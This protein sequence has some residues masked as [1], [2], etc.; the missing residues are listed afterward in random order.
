MFNPKSF[1]FEVDTA[2]LSI[3]EVTNL[4]NIFFVSKDYDW[5]Y[6]V[7]PDDVVVDIGAS[8]GMFSAKALDA[9]AKK[10]YMIEPSKKLLKTAVKNVSDYIIGNN[11]LPRVVPINAAVGR[12]DIDLSNVYGNNEVKLMSLLEFCVDF[13]VEQID[14][15]K[16]NAAGAEY[17]ILHRDMFDFLVTKVRHI[18][19]RC[20]LDAQYGSIDKFREWRDTVLNPMIALGRV[21]VQND[22]YIEKIQSDQFAELMPKSFMLYI[23]NW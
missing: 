17:N 5:W 20:H 15:L 8:V 4:H 3:N 19:V 14:F 23:R 7:L 21:Y 1:N 11:E 9:G 18:A 16:I 2:D 22:T 10:V 6:E 13:D 12:T